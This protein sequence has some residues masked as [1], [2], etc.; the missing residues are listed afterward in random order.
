MMGRTGA[1]V[2]ASE[3]AQTSAMVK[4]FQPQQR[5]NQAN[6]YAESKWCWL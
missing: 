5:L 6:R 3:T 1:Y 4:D 2:S